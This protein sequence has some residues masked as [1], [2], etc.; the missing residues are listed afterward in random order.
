MH[1]KTGTAR[2]PGAGGYARHAGAAH[3]A[4]PAVYDAPRNSQARNAMRIPPPADGQGGNFADQWPLHS[5]LELGAL[6]GAVPCARLHARQV[7]WEWQLT[8]LSDSAEL[9]VSELVTNAIHISRA[10]AR[11]APVRLWLLGD[12]ARAMILVQDASLLPPVRM[13]ACENDDNGRG[14][15]LVEN[16]SAQWG[17]YF[18]PVPGSGKVVWALMC[19][20][21]NSVR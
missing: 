13:S 4:A 1:G 3:P 21:L 12:R 20:E 2:N 16:F 11:A 14:L 15:L 7:L 10:N 9:L 8:G 6:P 18:P 5:F 17:W 19:P